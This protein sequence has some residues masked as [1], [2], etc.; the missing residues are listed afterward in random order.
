M[1]SSPISI[2]SSPYA[3]YLKS[4]KPIPSVRY[5]CRVVY[6]GP[7]IRKPPSKPKPTTP[8]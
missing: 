2:Q 6:S 7:R 8:H 1:D 4:G 5:S 3:D